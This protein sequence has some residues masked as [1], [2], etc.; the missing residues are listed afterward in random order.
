MK[1]DTTEKNDEV[2]NDL[3]IPAAVDVNIARTKRKRLTL[4]DKKEL[5]KKYQVARFANALKCVDKPEC[6]REI[7]CKK[8][9][10]SN[11]IA[12]DAMLC[13]WIS[14]E[15]LGQLEEWDGNNDLSKCNYKDSEVGVLDFI[16]AGLPKNKYMKIRLSKIIKKEYGCYAKIKIPKDTVI[17]YYQGK[18]VGRHETF[19]TCKIRLNDTQVID[20]GDFLSCHGRYINDADSSE[21]NVVMYRNTRETDNV[22]EF[23]RIKSTKAIEI[24]E[25]ILAHYGEEYWGESANAMHP[26]DNRKQCFL[27][28]AESNKRKRDRQ[29]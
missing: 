18:V 17:G 2:I 10:K 28:M 22:Q 13:K 21:P 20:A 29:A 5:V 16:N 1:D 4:A 3:S 15:R 25:E 12:N 11:N 6:L 14:M 24:D 26:N 23:F 9:C 8:F 19:S 27:K 7:S